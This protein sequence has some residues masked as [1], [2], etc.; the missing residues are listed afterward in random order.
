MKTFHV[1]HDILV[2]APIEKTFAV[3]T[4]FE[5][6]AELYPEVYVSVEVER[7]GNTVNTKE[8]IKSVAGKQSAGIRTELNPTASYRRDFVDGAMEGSVRS[9]TFETTPDGTLVKTDMDVKL[10]GM[11]AMLIGDLAE[12]LFT[13]NI[14]KLSNAHARVAEQ[15]AGR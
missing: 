9:T 10:A 11:V 4:D 3:W 13:K 1:H 6:W 8:V 12:T 7:N 5:H 2:K 14:E 15:E